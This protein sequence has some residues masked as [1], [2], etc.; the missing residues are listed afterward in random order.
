NQDLWQ[1]L[2]TVLLDHTVDW[3]WVKGHSGHPGN[4]RA[5]HLANMGCEK[6]NCKG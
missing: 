6:T 5:D 2:D 4:E 3:Q 1:R